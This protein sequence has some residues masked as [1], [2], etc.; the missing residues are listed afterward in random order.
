MFAHKKTILLSI[1]SVL[2][3]VA[4]QKIFQWDV[5]DRELAKYPN[6]IA[7]LVSASSKHSGANVRESQFYIVIPTTLNAFSV[8]IQ[9]DNGAISVDEDEYGALKWLLLIFVV[10]PLLSRLAKKFGFSKFEIKG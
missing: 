3:F 4:V 2:V 1:L 8:S 7:I 10:V 6:T 9:N 5:A